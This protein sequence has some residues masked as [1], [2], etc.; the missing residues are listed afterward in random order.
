M[1]D[2]TAGM[3]LPIGVTESRVLQQIAR[4]ESQLRKTQS[5]ATN[6]FIRSNKKVADSFKPIATEAAGMS[7]ATRGALQNV[8]YQV[9][10]V[11]VQ[12]QGGQGAVRALS[13]QLPQLLSGFGLVGVALGTIAPLVV[14]VGAALLSTGNDAEAVE[15]QMKA[16]ADA[17]SALEAAQKK[18]STSSVDLAAQFGPMAQQARELYAV[19]KQLAQLNLTRELNKTASMIGGSEFGGFDN[20]TAAEWE[21]FGRT[22]EEIRGRA[23]ALAKMSLTGNITEEMQALSQA[24]DEFLARNQNTIKQLAQMQTMFGV[25]AEQAGNLA[26]AFQRLN[27]AQGADNISAAAADLREQLAAALKN[28]D[29]T[30][31]AA[32]KLVE[33]LLNAEDAALRAKSVDIQGTISA[34]ADQAKRLADELSRAL[35][36]AAN[37]AAQGLN[38][39]RVAEIN[40]QYRTDS[41]GRAGALAALRAETEI[42]I[43]QGADDKTVARIEAQKAAYIETAR[44]A[45]KLNQETQAANEA[46]RKAAAEAAKLARER[47][48]ASKRAA[49]AEESAQ[50]RYQKSII[51][52]QG[53][54]SAVAE[55]IKAYQSLNLAGGSIE[56]QLTAIT[57][58]QKLL[59]AAQKAG[60]ELTPEQLA[61]ADRMAQ[62]YADQVEELNRL[63]DVASTGR[64]AMNTLF[65]S[66]LDGADAAKSA[67]ANL[68]MQI[69]KV[70]FSKGLMSLL[71]M[72]SGGSWLV[73]A[74][75][76]SLTMNANG[77]VYGGPG[78]SAYSGQVV[79]KPTLFPFAKGTGLMG[80]AGPEAILPLVRA[81]NGKLGVQS[82]GGGGASEPTSININV[83][84]ARGNS[85]IEQMV[86][87]GVSQGLSAYDKRLPGRVQ[88][89]NTNPRR[90]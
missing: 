52:L 45:A 50:E 8:G 44:A 17:I 49:K 54:T 60:I 33:Q 78:I 82:Q 87:S 14:G 85:E 25:N 35:T 81:A 24:D 3:E 88:Q 62:S 29:G 12:I 59:T 79:N 74:I 27:E 19:Q 57:E 2:Q 64:D 41:V 18:A 5:E 84:G 65:G 77:G 53:N 55:Q 72:T 86:A 69:A 11:I 70:Q 15:K 67:I 16:L 51:T 21:D 7:T 31:E 34:G 28:M 61:Q 23:E 89:I 66:I 75:G 63:R 26:A 56:A 32:V 20:K 39:L 30:N 83:T 80:E 4:I 68:L 36:N 76:S 38:E 73:N 47:E 10:D 1:A 58:K 43:P 6:N 40:N 9:Q 22:L 42:Q 37:L 90:R 71:G 48:A 13:Q 46:D